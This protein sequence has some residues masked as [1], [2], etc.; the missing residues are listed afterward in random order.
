MDR[1]LLAELVFQSQLIVQVNHLVS[2]DESYLRY[3]KRGLRLPSKI[4]T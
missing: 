1:L 4:A 3:E 2:W